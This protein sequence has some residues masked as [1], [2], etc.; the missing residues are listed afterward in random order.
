MVQRNF[1]HEKGGLYFWRRGIA[2]GEVRSANPSN[3]FVEDNLYTIVDENGAR[4]L[5][6][7]QWFGRLESLAAP[8]IRQFLNIVRHGMSPIMDPTYWDLWHVYNYHAQNALWP[9]TL[10]S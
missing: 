5:S 1:T 7:E 6:V 2:V 4:D 3:L 9:G 10:A 8:F